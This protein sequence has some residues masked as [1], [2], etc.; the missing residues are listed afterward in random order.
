MIYN[1]QTPD[2]EFRFFLTGTFFSAKMIDTSSIGVKGDFVCFFVNCLEHNHPQCVY[3]RHTFVIRV[4]CIH[5]AF[6]CRLCAVRVLFDR[7]QHVG[8]SRL[9]RIV[10]RALG[11]DDLEH[12]VPVYSDQNGNAFIALSSV[13]AFVARYFVSNNRFQKRNNLGGYKQCRF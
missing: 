5:Q 4:T 12:S 2:G 9:S 3:E 13:R 11:G 10:I 1:T 7:A 8:W 6:T